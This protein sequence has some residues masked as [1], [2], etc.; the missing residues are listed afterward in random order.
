MALRDICRMSAMIH[1][2]HGWRNSPLSRSACG[3]LHDEISHIK[4][5]DCISDLVVLVHRRTAGGFYR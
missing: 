3:A 5:V 1:R 4:L 2:G